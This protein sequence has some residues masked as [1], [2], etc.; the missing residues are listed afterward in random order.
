[1]SNF[2]E[3][4]K[5]RQDQIIKWSACLQPETTDMFQDAATIK[6]L[7]NPLFYR[8]DL[9]TLDFFLDDRI[10]QITYINLFPGCE[11]LE[12][13][14]RDASYF[15][16]ENESPIFYPADREYK[17][18][19]LVLE[20]NDKAYFVFGNKIYKWRMDHYDELEVINTPHY[21]INPGNTHVR[22]LYFDYY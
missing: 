21:A 10:R 16:M 19:H 15:I 2:I 20:T 4:L 5:S 13:T 17:T 11:V 18:T 9:L 1:M 6:P 14:H 22:F 12:H 8:D 3:E 7:K